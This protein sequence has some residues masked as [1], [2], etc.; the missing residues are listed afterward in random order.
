M[1]GFI[2]NIGIPRDIVDGSPSRTSMMPVQKAVEIYTDGASATPGV[3]EKKYAHLL[4]NK[5]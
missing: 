4:G 5:L 1:N 2:S 3:D